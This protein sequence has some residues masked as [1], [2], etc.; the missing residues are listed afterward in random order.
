MAEHRTLRVATVG[1]GRMGAIHA[2]N[3]ANLVSRAELVAVC[4]VRDESLAWAKEN[5]PPS[6]QTF[7]DAEEMF[8]SSGAEAVLI[9]T[10]TS[11]HAPLAELAISYGLVSDCIAQSP[12]AS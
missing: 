9:A 10:E 7:K 8:K 1:L 11:R 6:V 12:C 5:L 2:Y 4:D 3:Y